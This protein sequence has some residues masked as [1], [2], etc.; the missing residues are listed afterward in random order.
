MLQN[1]YRRK[2]L[3]FYELSVYAFSANKQKVIRDPVYSELSK[4][5]GYG[6]VILSPE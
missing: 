3:R 6:Q 5:V 2:G 1:S 4:N